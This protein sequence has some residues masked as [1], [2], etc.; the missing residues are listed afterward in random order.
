VFEL[1][2]KT[3]KELAKLIISK[4][5]KENCIL[6]EANAMKIVTYNGNDLQSLQ[7]EV[8]K[9]CAFTVEGEITQET[10][11][12]LVTKN[13]EAKVFALSDAVVTGDITKAM[14]QLDVLMFS[15]EEPIA[16][17]AVLSNAYVDMYRVK[18]TQESGES[19]SALAEKFPYKG[20]E[21]VISKAE[22]NARKLTLNALRRCLDELVEADLRLKSTR[23]DGRIVLE[24]L[25]SKLFLIHNQDDYENR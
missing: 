19:T 1:S 12:M 21:F 8:E 10:I 17:L 24:E 20:K 13:L 22:R 7:N 18:A 4:A 2:R 9:L 5:S 16:V 14:A 25:I 11:D 23:A 3:P 6:S 15:R